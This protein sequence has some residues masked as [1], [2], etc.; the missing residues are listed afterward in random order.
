MTQS[1]IGELWHR[2]S[3]L[4]AIAIVAMGWTLNVD[5]Q[6]QTPAPTTIS[7]EEVGEVLARVNGE[8]L[9]TETLF[10]GAE[11]GT[12]LNLYTLRA[13]TEAA[14]YDELV[15]QKAVALGLDKDPE[16]LEQVAVVALQVARQERQMLVG[17]YLQTI[18][19]I[20]AAMNR[21]G[22]KPTA[23][24][25]AAHI[26]QNPDELAQYPE[27]IR[28]RMAETQL[29]AGSRGAVNSARSKWLRQRLSKVKFTFR[30]GSGDGEALPA[31]VIEDAVATEGTAVLLPKIREI[32]AMREAKQRR[33]APSAIKKDV[34]LLTAALSAVVVE[35]DGKSLTLG[36]LPQLAQLIA[37]LDK[38]GSVQPLVFKAVTNLI[39]AADAREA[40]LE[41]DP[42]FQERQARVTQAV[43]KAR[44]GILAEF[45]FGRN[46]M[47]P[48]DV[49]LSQEEA[50]TEHNFYMST[51][52]AIPARDRAK[53]E[54][55]I[56]VHI[57]QMLLRKSRVAHQN[58]LRAEAE[59]ELL[60]EI[61]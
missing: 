8:P 52:K 24:E 29:T 16:Y 56:R 36:E 49:A 61:P 14:I 58:M 15:A 19:E 35:A 32:V 23:E 21:E 6:D 3:I 18:P 43:D 1:A 7:I 44:A 39:I 25:I 26:A 30:H 13:R 38:N 4:T 22:Y 33:V 42:Q 20:E 53:Q 57:E 60:V 31:A 9:L 54:D 40:G 12:K 48:D 2:T 10:P 50:R 34:A 11:A 51:F 46:G 5:A 37:R 17:F 27:D 45:Y 55:T 28:E 47:G 59:I 41:K